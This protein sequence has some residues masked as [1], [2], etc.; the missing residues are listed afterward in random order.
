MPELDTAATDPLMA[1]PEPEIAAVEDGPTSP[2]KRK[3]GFG[4]WVCAGWLIFLVLVA[5]FAPLL[6]ADPVINDRGRVVEGC[7]TGKGL[8]LYDALDC[9]DLDAK[10]AQTTGRGS[11]EFTHLAG[12]DSSGRDTFS[13]TVLGTRT[14]LL[15]AVLSIL[16]ATIVGGLLGLVSGYFG[17]KLDIVITGLFDVMVA[18]PA[19]IL[20]LLIVTV[21]SPPDDPA[22]ASRRVPGIILALAIVAVPI[23]GRIARASTLTWAEREFVTA[24]RALGAKPFR[25]I[26][27]DVLPNVAP[28][29]M[30]IAMLSVGIVIVAE[31]SLAILGLG[32]PGDTMSWGRVVAAGGA[33]FRQYPHLVF[34]PG[35]AIVITVCALNF[36]GDA[37]RQKFDV[38]ESAL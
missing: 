30:S 26:F 6:K 4:G 32:V 12:V 11:G 37:L 1:Q 20:A 33:N 31:A 18:F 21:F 22:G 19:L 29:M 14:T 16:A 23:L 10:R 36:L 34:V 13:Q 24:A 9:R 27:R 3:L 15:I 28:A 17:R 38:R 5:V 25:I 35:V 2:T 8:P 7:G